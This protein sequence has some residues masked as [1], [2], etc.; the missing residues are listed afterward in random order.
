MKLKPSDINTKGYTQLN[1][2]FASVDPASFVVLP[3]DQ[4]DEELMYAFTALKTSSLKTWIAVGG[5]GFSDPG[6]TQH[7]W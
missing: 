6:P 2:A 3:A 7:T 1:F 4:A 5:Y